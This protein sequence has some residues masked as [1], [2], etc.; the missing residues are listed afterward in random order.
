MATLPA[1]LLESRSGLSTVDGLFNEIGLRATG[2]VT[3]LQVAGRG[4]IA[5]DA[6]A[7]VLN[8]TVTEAAGPGFITV[9]PCGQAQPLASNLNYVAG[10]TIPNAV[11]TKI[12]Q[13]GKVCLFNSA[14]TH[15]IVDANGYFA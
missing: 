3:E 14:A 1:R 15:L 4:G 2:T 5:I 11:V 13:D 9:W 8:V 10:S 7:A 6:S 12:G